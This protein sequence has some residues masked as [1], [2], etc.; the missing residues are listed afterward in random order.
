M[1]DVA[2][3]S[4]ACSESRLLTWHNQERAQRSPDPFLHERVWSANKTMLTHPSLFPPPSSSSPSSLPLLLFSLLLFS[5]LP[6]P[7]PLPPPPPLLPPPLLPPSFRRQRELVAPML[8][9]VARTGNKD[10]LFKIWENGDD[11][12]PR[13]RTPDCYLGNITSTCS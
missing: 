6:P 1:Y 4:L 10:L 5:L 12:N 3:F 9:E 11:I 8:F 2:L 13:V 7:S